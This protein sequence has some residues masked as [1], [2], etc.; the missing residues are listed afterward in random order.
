MDS[1]R[2]R[3]HHEHDR[4]GD[5]QGPRR[6]QFRADG[7]RH[8]YICCDSSQSTSVKLT[9]PA[10]LA[11]TT[12]GGATGSLAGQVGTVYSVQLQTTTGIPPYTWTLASGNTLP[13]CLSM[14]SSGLITSNG[15]L[16]SNCAI[17]PPIT[18]DVT[19]SGNP[20]MTTSQQLELI[21]AP[22]PPIVFST[23]TIPPAT[24][25][26]NAAYSGSVL[27]SGGVGTLTYSATGLSKTGLSLN[28]ST[29]AITGTPT[30]AGVIS[31]SVTAADAFGDTNSQPYTV[32]VNPVTPT[33]SFA[34][35]ANQTFGSAPFQ[36]SATDAAS[37]VS[38]G[39]I[40]YSLT[41]GQSSAATV[42]SSGMVTLT[43]AGTVYLTATQAATAN[44]AA[45]T[46]TT[47]FTVNGET[48]ALT[49]A[50]ILP[51]PSAARPSR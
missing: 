48:P 35:I 1:E 3:K 45:A 7:N 14:T 33:L 12:T 51:K 20:P 11:V 40:T 2:R 41:P 39:A 37:A 9:I 4:L 24:G 31:F 26:Y 34:A 21:I 23:T 49:F 50:A 5:L 15:P 6:H 36:V 8:G 27:A 22:A 16:T 43:S 44:Y 47:S 30:A 10:Q 19:D 25:T 32:T 29:G 17:D 42:T 46:A 18:F 13:A 38:S 28:S